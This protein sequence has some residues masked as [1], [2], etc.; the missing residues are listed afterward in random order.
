MCIYKCMTK[1]TPVC[2][3]EV[4]IPSLTVFILASHHVA[5]WTPR[6]SAVARWTKTAKG[7]FATS[8]GDVRTED[9]S[10]TMASNGCTSPTAP[11]SK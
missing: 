10:S 11:R 5:Q 2:Y 6:P 7:S 8:Q 1:P 9:T 3:F 4:S